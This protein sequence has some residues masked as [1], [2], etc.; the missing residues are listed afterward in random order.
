MYEARHTHAKTFLK[1][2]FI[3]PSTGQWAN[4]LINLQT[5]VLSILSVSSLS[6][7]QLVSMPS[8]YYVVTS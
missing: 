4:E 1:L 7:T 8:V 6:I 5:A 2:T 3:M